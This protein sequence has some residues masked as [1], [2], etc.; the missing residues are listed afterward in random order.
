M[1]AVSSKLTG[2]QRFEGF[3]QDWE[4]IETIRKRPWPK[5]LMTIE[6]QK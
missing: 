3:A 5:L 2:R 6:I 4:A 1:S